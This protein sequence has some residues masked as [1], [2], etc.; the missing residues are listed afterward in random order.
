[1]SPKPIKKR[2]KVIRIQEYFQW[3]FPMIVSIILAFLITQIF[4]N[5]MMVKGDSMAPVCKQGDIVLINKISYHFKNPE[6]NDIIV[7]DVNTLNTEDLNANPRYTLSRII[8]M[9]GETIQIKDGEL[10]INEEKANNPYI[11][12]IILQPGVEIEPIKL[13]QNEY[14][15]LGDNCNFSQDS[16]FANIGNIKK[17]A[18]LGKVLLLH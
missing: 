9:P 13:K 15:V 5:A 1:M 12:D 2:R 7:F 17:D 4:G 6:R 3:V 16:R 10:Y 18:M 8:G 11:K 14:F